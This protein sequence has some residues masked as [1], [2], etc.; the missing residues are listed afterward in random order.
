MS[1]R[2]IAV[3]DI[4][5]CAAA[6]ESV[7]DAACLTSED[8]IVT[9]GDYVDRG[10][11]SKRVLECLCQL[12]RHLSVEMLLGN[13]EIMMLAAYQDPAE[14][15]FWLDCGGDATLASYGGRLDDIPAEHVELLASCQPYYENDTHFFVHANYL[16]AYPLEDQPDDVR[17]WL[18]L[19]AHLPGP[20]RNGKRAV[21]GHTPQPG[22]DVLA[23][24]HILAIDTHCYAGG[25]LTA[26]D[27]DSGR[28]WQADK[29]GE[30]RRQSG[31]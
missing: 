30:V 9:L 20:H 1:G 14:R 26:M 16:E 24:D 17:Y 31:R 19:H 5:G 2:T 28:V 15:K 23:L 21:V 22:G 11:D 10:T 12:R 18:H 25:W 13:H 8:R 27:V 29:F 6:L 7:L 3:G 4:H